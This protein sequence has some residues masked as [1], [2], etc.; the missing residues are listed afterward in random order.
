MSDKINVL[1]ISLCNISKED[2]LHK[3][4]KGVLFTPNVDQLVKLQ[5]NEQFYHAY[6][7]ADWVVCDSRIVALFLK[8]LGCPIKQVIPGSSFFPQYCDYHK[9][10]EDIRIF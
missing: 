1:N 4:N 5:K 2:L 6:N 9:T 7:D 10:N 8:F 3:M